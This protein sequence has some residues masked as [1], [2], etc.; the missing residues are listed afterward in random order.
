MHNVSATINIII[1]FGIKLT[2]F[3][4]FH[5]KYTIVILGSNTDA[6]YSHASGSLIVST[7]YLTYFVT[8]IVLALLLEAYGGSSCDERSLHMGRFTSKYALKRW[9]GFENAD[10]FICVP[11]DPGDEQNA[12]KEM[13]DNVNEVN[14]LHINNWL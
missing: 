6:N 7:N 11:Y 5:I 8:S 12:M 2:N 14:F 4:I 10:K 1:I 9:H 13:D 3:Y